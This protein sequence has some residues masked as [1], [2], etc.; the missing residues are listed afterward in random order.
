MYDKEARK[1]SRHG[2]ICA[3]AISVKAKRNATKPE[4][5]K[6]LYDV[7][8]A[9]RAHWKASPVTPEETTICITST[10]ELYSARGARNFR[11]RNEKAE[12]KPEAMVKKSRRCLRPWNSRKCGNKVKSP[13]SRG[14]A[15][16]RPGNMWRKRSSM[17]SSCE[18]MKAERNIVRRAYESGEKSAY[19][20]R[21][22]DIA[23]FAQHKHQ[24]KC[25][26]K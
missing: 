22:S 15:P 11:K 5:E 7:I 16:S 9:R 3:S 25:G 17:Q 6:A 14:G 2:R 13:A 12:E 23:L 10:W 24:K 20:K 21:I 18:I 4:S 19:V 8:S 26:G 1:L